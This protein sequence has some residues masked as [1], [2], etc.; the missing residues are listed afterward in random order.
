[1]RTQGTCDQASCD[2]NSYRMGATSFYRPGLTVHT[3]QKIT[4]A[5]QFV[6]SPFT[7]IRRFY[8]QNG[9]VIP[10]SNGTIPGV[11]GNAISNSFCA[12]QKSAFGDTNTFA[13]K[14][15]M[16]TTSRAAS[17]GMILVMS[18]WVFPFLLLHEIT[19]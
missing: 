15:R 4:V 16:A 17:A 6:G 7:S 12:A 9:R 18:I 14:G 1:N 5:P 11:T 8:V 10:H 3:N 13:S 19:V 2:F